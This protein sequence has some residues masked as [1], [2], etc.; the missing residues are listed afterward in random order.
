MMRSTY[1]SNPEKFEEV[2]KIN[3]SNPNLNC[4]QCNVRHK[5]NVYLF[6]S[7]E[8]YVCWKKRH[9]A[10]VCKSK[11]FRNQLSQGREK[12]RFRLSSKLNYHLEANKIHTELMY[13]V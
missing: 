11:S 9:T 13:R 3:A 1:S 10:K 6:K 12:D 2:C 7:K 4:Y 5:V 8:C